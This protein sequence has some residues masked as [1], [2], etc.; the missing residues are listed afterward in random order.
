MQRKTIQYPTHYT[1]DRMARYREDI[2]TGQYCGDCV[3]GAIKGAAWTDLGQH[4][5]KYASNDVPDRSADGMFEYCKSLG[6]EHGNIKTIPEKPGIAVRMA[7]H[8]GIYVGKG[9]VDEWRG[10]K[11][12]DVQTNLTDRGWTDW[13][14]LPWV[15]YGTVVIEPDTNKD[16]ESILGNRIL[17]YGRTGEDVELLQELLNDLGFD[18]G[19][20]DGDF[21]AKTRNAVRALQAAAGLEVDGEF[22]PKTLA[23]LM[24]L[25]AEK[26]VGDNIAT[27]KEKVVVVTADV[28]ANV[29]F[30]PGTNYGIITAAKRDAELPYVGIADNGWY[31]VDVGDKV[32]WIS[33]KMAEKK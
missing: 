19:K 14:E 10:F 12:G 31:A 8:V 6:A 28:S 2:A 33:N 9:K 20:A 4:P 22:G 27:E 16:I 3:G 17:K 30:G 1:A 15:D 21:G 7:G 18:C 24:S 23:A 26:E 5:M 25:I 32:G 11:Y 13:Y 29:R